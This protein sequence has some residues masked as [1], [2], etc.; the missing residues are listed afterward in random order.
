M[1]HECEHSFLQ[2][3]DIHCLQNL[4]AKF[5]EE[6]MSL[7]H[8]MSNSMLNERI[9]SFAMASYNS[10]IFTV[11]RRIYFDSYIVLGF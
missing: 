1:I 10:V 8:E 4:Q 5:I 9:K 3:R 7:P 2:Q 6:Y 11:T